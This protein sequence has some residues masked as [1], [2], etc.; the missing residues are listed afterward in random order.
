MR[1]TIIDT[2][3]DIILRKFKFSVPRLGKILKVDDDEK[4]GRVLV[5]IPVLGWTTQDNG[6]WCYPKDKKKIITP[7][8]NDYVVVEWLD[9]EQ[10]GIALYSGVSYWMTGML[11][12]NYDGKPTTQILFEDNNQESYISYNETTKKFL[13]QI[14]TFIFEMDTQGKIFRLDDGSNKISMNSTAGSIDI[15]GTLLNMFAATE[16][17]VKGNTMCTALLALCA[18]IAT[19]TSGSTAQNAGG[20]NIIKAAFATFNGTINSFKSTT[21][22]GE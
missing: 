19:A 8:I 15:T 3:I 7:K 2:I 20:I 12:K 14:K 5:S 18:T 22:K 21:I 17:F 11:P 9:G 10:D 1:S 6:Q 4:K 13:I 16:S